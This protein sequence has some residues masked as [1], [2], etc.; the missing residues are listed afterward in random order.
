MNVDGNPENFQFPA[1]Y[2]SVKWLRINRWKIGKDPL[3]LL[4][5]G[6]SSSDVL[7]LREHFMHPRLLDSNTLFVA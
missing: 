5:R 7:F 4:D 3:R 1:G 6:I 2:L